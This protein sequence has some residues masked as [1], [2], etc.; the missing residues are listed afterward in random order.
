[1]RRKTTAPDF[2]RG[3]GEAGDVLALA[4]GVVATSDSQRLAAIV[5]SSVDAIIGLDLAG[6]VTSWNAAATALFGYSAE[7]MLGGP[8]ARLIPPEAIAGEN[9]L[10]EKLRR[11]DRVEAIET[12]RRT[13]DGRIIGVSVA[14][15]AVRDCDGRMV[16]TS[17]I[18]RTASAPVRDEP[19]LARITRLYAGLRQV[20]QAI[21]GTATREALFCQ[22][23]RLLVEHAGLRMAWIGWNDPECQPRFAVLRGISH[24]LPGRGWGHAQRVCG[25]ARFLPGPGACAAGR[26]GRRYFLCPGQLRA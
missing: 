18:V 6:C 16:G 15:S 8:V 2:A 12:R 14:I 25:P 26:R 22:V 17:H 7:S 5:E 21:S 4:A 10:V 9:A 1:M 19:E 20:N 13:R 24:P 11:G 23:C 3:Y